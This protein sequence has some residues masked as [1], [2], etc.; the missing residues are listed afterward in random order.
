[1]KKDFDFNNPVITISFDETEFDEFVKMAKSLRGSSCDDV[2]NSSAIHNDAPESAL[3][4]STESTLNET[5]ERNY[6][7]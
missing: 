2:S 5:I 6:L 7:E 1:M 4:E 3:R